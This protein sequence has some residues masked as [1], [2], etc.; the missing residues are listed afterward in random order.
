MVVVRFDGQR[1]VIAPDR[2]VPRGL[3][4]LSRHRFW[5]VLVALG[6]TALIEIFSWSQGFANTIAG[7]A[8]PAAPAAVTAAS[9]LRPQTAATMS[10]LA[11]PPVRVRLHTP[12]SAGGSQASPDTGSNVAP[13]APAS[14]VAAMVADITQAIASTAP[15]AAP[16]EVEA[17]VAQPIDRVQPNCD[18]L[19]EALRQARGKTQR[20]AAEQALRDLRDTLSGCAVTTGATGGQLIGFAP[21]PGFSI[22]GSP[23]Y[24]N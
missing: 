19:L 6:I 2:A 24:R 23:D 16:A 20:R 15:D 8:H 3:M 21:I 22:G 4:L 13:S 5:V 9:T 17:V 1:C 11:A 10:I 7:A 14:D 18:V 12:P